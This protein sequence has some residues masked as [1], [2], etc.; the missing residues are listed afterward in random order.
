MRDQ[1]TRLSDLPLPLILRPLQSCSQPPS[2]QHMVSRSP[3]VTRTRSGPTSLTQVPGAVVTT[4][5]HHHNRHQAARELHLWTV[6][7]HWGISPQSYILHQIQTGMH[8]S[9]YLCKMWCLNYFARL[10]IVIH[11]IQDKSIWRMSTQ[12]LWDLEWSVL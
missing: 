6:S 8:I 3:W 9:T 12:Y 4:W 11:H 10:L 7:K 5:C 1:L 2:W